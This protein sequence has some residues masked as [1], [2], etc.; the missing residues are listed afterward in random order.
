MKTTTYYPEKDY[1]YLAVWVGKDE[2]L[3]DERIHNIQIKD[4][5]I[6]S[7]VDPD[8]D[9]SID[10]VPYVQYLIGGKQGYITKHENEYHPLP[11]GY[12]ITLTQ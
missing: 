8:S 3:T 11:K 6:I 9:D 12:T 4:I 7:M 5:V 10:K 2:S 1:P